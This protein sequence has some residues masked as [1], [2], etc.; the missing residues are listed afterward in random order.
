[1]EEE[2]AKAKTP[3]SS[4]SKSKPSL[5][6]S[7][8]SSPTSSKKATPRSTPRSRSPRGK[9]S[10]QSST[11]APPVVFTEADEISPLRETS[12]AAP[13]RR[14]SRHKGRERRASMMLEERVKKRRESLSTSRF[15]MTVSEMSASESST[16]ARWKSKLEKKRKHHRKSRVSSV[17]ASSTAKSQIED[18]Q[19]PLSDS[20]DDFDENFRKFLHFDMGKV[21]LAM[22]TFE[23][24]L[25][26]SSEQIVSVERQIRELR[27]DV[28]RLFPVDLA[29]KV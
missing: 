4:P 17:A 10:R 3:P 14:K 24:L 27:S 16:G 15:D 19:K 6:H 28:D 29:D 18:R 23:E 22:A 26:K 7:C 8:K 12:P 13:H 25:S 1:M 9:H 5:P 11:A 2:I 20:Q 21:V